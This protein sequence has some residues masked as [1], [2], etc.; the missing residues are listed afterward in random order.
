MLLVKIIAHSV[1]FC[2]FNAFHIAK[3]FWQQAT[4]YF[5]LFSLFHIAIVRCLDFANFKLTNQIAQSVASKSRR[6]QCV[7]KISVATEM[8]SGPQSTRLN[9][10]VSMRVRVGEVGVAVYR[11][12][13]RAAQLAQ[14]QDDAELS[15]AHWTMSLQNSSPASIFSEQTER[16]LI[17]LL[18]TLRCYAN[19]ARSQS[20][21][22]IQLVQWKYVIQKAS[23]PQQRLRCAQP[24]QPRALGFLN[25][26]FPRTRCIKIHV[27]EKNRPQ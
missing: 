10:C 22:V 19:R 21:P 8:P 16:E 3:D 2:V 25:H 26:V 5:F 7:R 24:L 11:A 6:S 20:K 14:S 23:G 13:T 4:Q 9:I 15:P 17:L 1:V 27:N 12:R 18:K